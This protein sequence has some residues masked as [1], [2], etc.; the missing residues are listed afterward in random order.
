MAS[1]QNG[2]KLGELGREE[3]EEMERKD[4]RQVGG[5]RQRVLVFLHIH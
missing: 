1:E 5:E 2:S 4:I 3:E